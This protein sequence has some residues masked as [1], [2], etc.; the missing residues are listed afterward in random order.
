[1]TTKAAFT[2]QEWDLVRGAPPAAGMLVI[3]A[4]HGGMMRETVEM[5]KVY[6]E[7]RQ[8]HGESEFLDELVAS[9]PK[10]E[11]VKAHSPEELKERTL[12]RLGEAVATV[13]AKATPAEVDDY[14]RFITTLTERVAKRHKEDDVEVSEAEQ[15]AIDDVR[16]AL[17]G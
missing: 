8:Q 1:M 4:S 12:Q 6:A 9:K 16:A 14:R 17:G 11:R 3:T 13:S 2:E 5:A 10:S 7:A 15:Q